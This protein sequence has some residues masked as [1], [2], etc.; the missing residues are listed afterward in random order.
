ML[1]EIIQIRG[2]QCAGKSW[3]SQDIKENPDIAFF[4]LLDLYHSR[5]LIQSDDRMDWI[6]WEELMNNLPEIVNKFIKENMNKKII[7]FEHSC[8]KSLSHILSKY[9]STVYHLETPDIGTIHRYAE[10]R[11]LN[12]GRV[13]QFRNKYIKE[14]G[15]ITGAI[16]SD[17]LRIILNARIYG[18][19]VGVIGTA[20]RKEDK[21]KMS[22]ELF[23]RMAGHT[24]QYLH[25][26]LGLKA[27]NI[28]MVSGGAAWADHIAVAMYLKDYAANLTLHLPANLQM[29]I[30]NG[31]N[32]GNSYFYGNK[33]ADTAN[34]YHGL[35]TQ[36]CNMHTLNQIAHAIHKGAQVTYSSDFK[37]RNLLVA[38]EA[39]ILLAYTWGE[40]NIPKDGGTSHTWNN[41]SA[42][43]KKHIPL[44]ILNKRR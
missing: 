38:K 33:S 5:G 16:S 23:L 28:T 7:I 12:V 8:N 15:N 18:I 13:I 34:Y 31:P 40:G 17:K 1:T 43:I 11:K 42:I 27:D 37:V 35:M 3:A 22:R 19:K 44:K 14:Y 9:K 6:K 20:G 29:F 39:Q 21:D 36:K 24:K 25:E 32:R 10:E 2:T 41:S 30:N 26:E 4:D